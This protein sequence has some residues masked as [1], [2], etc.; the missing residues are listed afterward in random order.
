MKTIIVTMLFGAVLISGSASADVHN[1]DV[2]GDT[3]EKVEE[4]ATDQCVANNPDGTVALTVIVQQKT[5]LESAPGFEIYLRRHDQ[6][7]HRSGCRRVT[8]HG[9]EKW[10]EQQHKP[11]SAHSRHSLNLPD[12]YK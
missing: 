2:Y 8:G 1:F 6:L 10:N 5:Q 3:L 9:E 12:D 7:P 11:G 4:A